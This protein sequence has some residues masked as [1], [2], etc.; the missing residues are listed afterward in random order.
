MPVINMPVIQQL[1]NNH[2]Y[3]SIASE[4]MVLT[5]TID[6]EKVQL[7]NIRTHINVS[8]S[9]LANLLNLASSPW[10]QVWM[11]CQLEPT[12]HPTGLPWIN[13]LTPVIVTDIN[14]NQFNFVPG[15]QLNNIVRGNLSS[16]V[17]GLPAATQFK[18]NLIKLDLSQITQLNSW[19]NI[20]W[21]HSLC[22]TYSGQE[23]L[24]FAGSQVQLDAIQLP[25]QPDYII[26]TGGADS[27]IFWGTRQPLLDDMLPVNSS[28]TYTGLVDIPD[29]YVDL[30]IKLGQKKTLEQLNQ[31][32][33][34]QLDTEINQGVAQIGQQLQLDLQLEQANYEKRKYGQQ[35]RP[36]GAV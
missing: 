6:N 19:E 32:V 3:Q 12:L 30:L 25:A 29:Q 24:M 4:I 5:N 14:N 13:L 23:I 10:Y 34:Q 11:Q 36:P 9:Y 16:S 8:I 20:Q 18:G 15:R 17:V 2:T 33:P 28:L 22:W 27:L 7:S 1:S 31:I 26:N 35:Q 21:R